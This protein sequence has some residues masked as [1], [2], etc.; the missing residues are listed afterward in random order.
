L[1]CETCNAYIHVLH[2]DDTEKRSIHGM[3]EGLTCHQILKSEIGTQIW[4]TGDAGR[5]SV[6][7]KHTFVKELRTR[8]EYTGSNKQKRTSE[9]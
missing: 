2:L 5:R 6:K 1:F 8:L 4:C 7:T 3:F 9:P